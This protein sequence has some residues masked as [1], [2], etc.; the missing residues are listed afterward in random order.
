M[1]LAAYP[2]VAA[3]CG[4]LRLLT[5][6]TVHCTGGRATGDVTCFA[7]RPR[8]PTMEADAMEPAVPAVNEPP[9][10]P[11]VTPPPGHAA[12]A[13]GWVSPAGARHAQALY[14]MLRSEGLVLRALSGDPE[15]AGPGLGRDEVA[16]LRLPRFPD[17]VWVQWFAEASD[18]FPAAGDPLL[19][20]GRGPQRLPASPVAVAAGGR[21]SAAGHAQV[22]AAVAAIVSAGAVPAL[23]S[24]DPVTV[25]L[26]VNGQVP[27]PV[28]LV[29]ERDP[30]S[31]PLVSRASQ[32]VLDR[33]GVSLWPSIPRGSA[34]E[35]RRHEARRLHAALATASFLVEPSLHG[36]HSHGLLRAALE[37]PRPLLL[38]CPATSP[39]SA[40]RTA[41]ASLTGDRSTVATVVGA[42]PHPHLA[43]FDVPS[44]ADT[45]PALQ[46]ALALATR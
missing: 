32:E 18:R 7:G 42:S 30:A 24:F 2:V 10:G 14:D 11:V 27:G 13:P 41:H 29:S 8:A 45:S 21:L 22:A 33:G 4:L 37:R 44:A 15:T 39:L 3:A 38:P 26:L 17:G 23:L 46:A 5:N 34:L 9:T 19:V 35:V 12:P 40:V 1:I 28:V 16:V 43:V 6:V 36:R 25:P 20:W 31:S